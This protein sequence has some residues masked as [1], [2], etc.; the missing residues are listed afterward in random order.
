[1]NQRFLQRTVPI[2]VAAAFAVACQERPANRADRTPQRHEAKV[3]DSKLS[4]AGITA[5]IDTAYMVN[6]HLSATAIDVD[7]DHGV[8]TLSGK[9]PSDVHRDLAVAIAK[10]ADG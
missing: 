6:P 5:R 3:D 8:V 9:V 1:M 2:A 7:T 4:D 10:S